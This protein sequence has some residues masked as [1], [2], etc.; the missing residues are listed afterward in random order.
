MLAA[1]AEVPIVVLAGQ[2]EAEAAEPAVLAVERLQLLVQITLVVAAG[3]LLVTL[4]A[5][6][7]AQTAAPVS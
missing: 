6:V 4:E 2:A 1:A 7:R 3:A 5:I